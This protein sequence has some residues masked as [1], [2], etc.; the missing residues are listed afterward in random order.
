[1]NYENE[2]SFFPFQ[3]DKLYQSIYTFFH[4]KVFNVTEYNFRNWIIH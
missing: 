2:D 1:M 4:N 3:P